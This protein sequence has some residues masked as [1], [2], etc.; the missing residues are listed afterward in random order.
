MHVDIETEKK[1]VSLIQLNYDQ[2]KELEVT[3]NEIKES[4]EISAEEMTLKFL[5]ADESKIY[6]N[7]KN[8]ENGIDEKL[9]FS[10]KYWASYVKYLPDGHQN[11]GD[12]I[13]RP[14]KGEY[15]SMSY[16]KYLNG[17]I[18]TGETHS[19]MDFYFSLAQEGNEEQSQ[20]ARV[21]VSIDK[22]LQ[23]LK[24]DVDLESLPKIVFDGYE[25]TANFHVENFDNNQTFYTDSNGLE[26]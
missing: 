19:Q 23:V 18:S 11:S 5:G 21:H 14:I 10:L 7:F 22:E 4:D 12:Y 2:S 8:K 9:D 20:E 24:F 13:F 26:M 1:D 15:E 25:V 3:Q 6:F 16:S 17:T